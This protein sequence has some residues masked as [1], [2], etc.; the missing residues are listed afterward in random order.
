M[1]SIWYP[2][3]GPSQCLPHLTEHSDVLLPSL[4]TPDSLPHAIPPALY[5]ASPP[6]TPVLEYS[7]SLLSRVRLSLSCTPKFKHKPILFPPKSFLVLRQW[8]FQVLESTF[9]SPYR[10]PCSCL[11]FLLSFICTDWLIH[12]FNSICWMSAVDQV[13]LWVLR[14]KLCTRWTQVL[15]SWIYIPGRMYKMLRRNR[16]ALPHSGIGL[17]IME[18]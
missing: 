7:W 11:L 12:S 8:A 18:S 5:S 2:S 6:R 4:L 3:P 1:G 15:S 14:V 9:C 16:K 10:R 17:H 13:P